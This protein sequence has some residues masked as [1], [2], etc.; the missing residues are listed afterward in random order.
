MRSDEIL[1]EIRQFIEAELLELK[2]I[3]LD[4]GLSDEGRG[5]MEIATEVQRILAKLRA[6]E[7]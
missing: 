7:E 4:Q 3:E 5:C 6:E 2:E 1:A